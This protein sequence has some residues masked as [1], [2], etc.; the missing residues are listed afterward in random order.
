ME[1][2]EERGRRRNS[3]DLPSNM[4]YDHKSVRCKLRGGKKK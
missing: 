2:D 1:E 4:V 3:G